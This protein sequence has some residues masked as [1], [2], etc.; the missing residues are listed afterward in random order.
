MLKVPLDLLK[1]HVRADDITCD[2]AYLSDCLEAAQAQV[3][4][5]TGWT[6]KE[7]APIPNDAFP[8]DIRRAVIMRAASLYAYREDIDTSS[9][10]PLPLSTAAMLKPY[11]KMCGGGIMDRLVEKY[12]KE[13][14]S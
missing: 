3:I 14:Q 6:E 11:R 7:L 13:E 1:M 2:D 8:A 12:G 5:A 9:L 4:N 10:S